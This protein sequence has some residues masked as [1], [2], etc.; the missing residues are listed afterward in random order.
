MRSPIIAFS[1]IAAVGPAIV[2]AAPQ[3]S[4]RLGGDAIAHP[5]NT[6]VQRFAKLPRDGLFGTDAVSEAASQGVPVSS[7][8]STFGGA[9]DS[10]PSP[11]DNAAANANQTA[12]DALA[13]QQKVAAQQQRLDE[14]QKQLENKEASLQPPEDVSKFDGNQD[15]SKFGENQ[16]APQ[17]V[18]QAAAAAP[19]SEAAAHQ[20]P[21][22]PVFHAYNQRPAPTAAA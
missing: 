10:A 18:P 14:Q 22:E 19:V 21:Q 20:E 1:L 15:V 4:P 5:R 8:F 6:E 12:A 9:S 13:Q 7:L 2:S 16:A 17:A 11:D 3:G